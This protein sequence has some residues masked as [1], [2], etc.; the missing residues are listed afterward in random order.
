M[1]WVR[2]E[3]LIDVGPNLKHSL[4]MYI[5][6]R[7]WLRNFA[8]AALLAVVLGQFSLLLHDVLIDH[9]ADSVCEL[10]AGHDRLADGTVDVISGAFA[11][12]AP[13]A[14]FLSVATPSS[15]RSV[16]VFRPRGPPLV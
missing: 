1:A 10:C 11:F 15:V 9:E 16:A 5:D 12:V 4:G 14:A 8:A 6:L 2:P 7:T 13:A 3:N